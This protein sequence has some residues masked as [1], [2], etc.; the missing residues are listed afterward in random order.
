M[1]PTRA[2]QKSGTKAFRIISRRV[3]KRQQVDES[4]ITTPSHSDV[5]P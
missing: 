1:K 3:V 2:K 5:K 4:N